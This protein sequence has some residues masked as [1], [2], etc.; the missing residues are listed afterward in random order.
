[1]PHHD[2]PFGACDPQAPSIGA[3][4]PLAPSGHATPVPHSSPGPGS[5]PGPHGSPDPELAAILPVITGPA[6]QF[7]H[8]QHINLAY[9]AV[10][11]YGMPD[12]IGTICSWIRQIAAYE[13]APQKYHHTV[14]RAWVEIVAYH[15]DADPDC[16]DFDTFAT[17]NPALLDKRL[18]NSHYRSATL[19]ASPARRGWVEPDLTPFPW[20]AQGSPA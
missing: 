20:S 11:R 1:M 7:R 9:Y 15:V 16:A 19:A 2:A 14:S 10:R 12:A 18:L 17:R 5:S 8:R 6:G 13:R 3:C 4:G